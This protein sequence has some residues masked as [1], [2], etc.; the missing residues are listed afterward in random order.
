MILNECEQ[1]GD[2]SLDKLD[3]RESLF[4][5]SPFRTPD[6]DNM[7]QSFNRPILNKRKLFHYED[8]N[9]TPLQMTMSQMNEINAYLNDPMQVRFSVY[10]KNSQFSHL[11]M[12]VKRVFSVQASS[13][14]IERVFSQAGVI[15]SPRRT[16]MLEE[17]FRSLVF[18]HVNQHLFP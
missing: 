9:G 2:G 11:K 15:M 3:S 17:V 14:P 6:D 10:W 5:S 18:L 1:N 13:A 16:L 7:T 8:H 12:I 4:S